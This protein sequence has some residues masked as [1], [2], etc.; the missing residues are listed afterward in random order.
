MPT[1]TLPSALRWFC[2]LVYVVAL[3]SPA[4]AQ[5][6]VVQRGSPHPLFESDSVL[7]LRVRTDFRALLKDRD[8]ADSRYH[9]ATLTY[10]DGD[11][12]VRGLDVELKTRGNFRLRTCSFPPLRIR[13]GPTAEGTQFQGE[14]RLKI[15]NPC[16]PRR[17][18][19][20][21]FLLQEYLLY[22]IYGLLTPYSFRARLARM[23]FEDASGR[24]D[25]VEQ[26]GFFIESEDGLAER[27]GGYILAAQGVSRGFMESDHLKLMAVFQYM[28]A[29]TDWSI[30]WLHNI[31]LVQTGPGVVHPVP[32]DLDWS[33][34]IAPPYA[35]P[36]TILPIRTV[37]DRLYRGYCIRAAELRP[38]L[39]RF[40]EK[41]SDIY[42]LLESL[43][44]LEMGR[45]NRMRRDFDAFYRIIES[46]RA[47]DREIR[48]GCL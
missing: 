30:T 36:D 8:T 22:R 28:V 43:P 44:Q 38:A 12:A 5:E 2:V 40:R 17:A 15:V 27:N 13:F 48:R 3:A 39:D 29:N 34:V 11:G 35:T 41:K 16:H 45:R 19:F 32:Y 6:L 21:Q 31:R 14:D 24:K 7:Q 10:T 26:F 25:G 1:A 4:A 46:E 47:L 18:L 23:T 33:G 20:E 37:R 9:P 42:A